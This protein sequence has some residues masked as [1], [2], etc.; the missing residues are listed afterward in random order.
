MRKNEAAEYAE[1]STHQDRLEWMLERMASDVRE[2]RN[3]IVCL[4]WLWWVGFSIAVLVTVTS[5]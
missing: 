3:I 4:W 2:V 5:S 1:L